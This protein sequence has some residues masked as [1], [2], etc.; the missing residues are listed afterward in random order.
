MKKVTILAT[1]I[2]VVAACSRPAQSQIADVSGERIRA[3]V[4]YLASDLLEGRAPGSR[5]GNLATEYIATQ[6]ALIGAKPFG[7]NGTYFQKLHLVGVGL[8]SC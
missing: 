7:D 2:A 4:R 6:F 3:H 5:G 8:K 1:A